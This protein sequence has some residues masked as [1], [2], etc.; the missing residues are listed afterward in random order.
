MI[1]VEEGTT[2]PDSG[3]LNKGTPEVEKH[4]N[5]DGQQPET[6]RG[7]WGNNETSRQRSGWLRKGNPMGRYPFK[8]ELNRYLMS[9]AFV[10]KTD[11]Y[12]KQIRFYLIKCEGYMDGLGLSTNPKA[13]K[14][15]DIAILY[16]RAPWVS[17]HEKWMILVRLRPFLAWCGNRIMY[18]LK[19]LKIEQPEGKRNKYTVNDL[20]ALQLAVELAGDPYEQWLLHLERDY[21]CRRI[22][23]HRALVKDFDIRNEV[24]ILR[25]KGRGGTKTM[26]AQLHQDTPRYLNQVLQRRDEVLAQC[27]ELGYRGEIPPQ[28]LLTQ[29][30][31]APH[32]MSK[33]NLDNMLIHICKRAGVESRGHHATRRGVATAIYNE[34]KDLVATQAF[35]GHADPKTTELYIGTGLD[36]Q[37]TA[38][39]ALTKVLTR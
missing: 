15:N 4:E 16:A 22:S 9:D 13:I 10:G 19:S 2:R 14:S 8:A 28:I 39:D 27:K 29:Y 37:K 38:Q 25:V 30:R 26:Q 36:K 5:P 7:A 18:E 12:R 6:P 3:A 21:G 35:L 17:E 1:P 33:S 23:V 31:N 20:K 11:T 32:P 34:T 24:A